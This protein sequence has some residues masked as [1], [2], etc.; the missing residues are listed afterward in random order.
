MESMGETYFKGVYGTPRSVCVPSV[1]P[2]VLDGMPGRRRRPSARRP[3][4]RQ[5]GRAIMTVLAK[6][7]KIG[8]KLGRDKRYKR[9]GAKCATGH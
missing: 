1:V 7:D 5:N 2:R 9:M 6:A 3:R 8:Y 4:F